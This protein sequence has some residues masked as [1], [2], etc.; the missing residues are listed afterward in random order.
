MKLETA[1]GGAPVIY[2]KRRCI[3][4]YGNEQQQQDFAPY[5]SILAIP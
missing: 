1:A 2:C 3:S 5:R 4:V